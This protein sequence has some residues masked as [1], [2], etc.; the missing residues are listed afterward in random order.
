MDSCRPAVSAG[1]ELTFIC[2]TVGKSKKLNN[3]S[4]EVP[5]KTREKLGSG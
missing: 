1:S 5:S 4:T 2:P 3:V